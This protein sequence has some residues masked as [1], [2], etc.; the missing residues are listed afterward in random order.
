[1]SIQI[2]TDSASD[3]PKELLQK[4]C[5]NVVPLTISYNMKTYLDGIDFSNEA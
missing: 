1:M 5:I 4:H 2:V 3:L